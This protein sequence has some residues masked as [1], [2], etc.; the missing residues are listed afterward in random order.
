MLRQVRRI[1]H[2]DAFDERAALEVRDPRLSLQSLRVVRLRVVNRK[3]SLAGR[4]WR[5]LSNRGGRRRRHASRRKKPLACEVRRDSAGIAHYPPRLL[6][7]FNKT[8]AVQH[9]AGGR[10]GGR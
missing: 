6:L 9:N 4:R 10:E 7:L 8:F 2:D 1:V 3:G 5:L